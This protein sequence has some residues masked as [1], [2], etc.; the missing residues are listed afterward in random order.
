MLFLS[1]AIVFGA[2]GVISNSDSG[3]ESAYIESARQD[4]VYT[5][6]SMKSVK[7]VKS[8]DDQ[9]IKDGPIDDNNLDL[10]ES[11]SQSAYTGLMMLMQAVKLMPQV[12]KYASFALAF[13]FLI[14]WL[15]PLG[16]LVS[17]LTGTAKSREVSSRQQSTQSQKLAS[18]RKDRVRSSKG[19]KPQSRSNNKQHQNQK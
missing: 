13:V 16:S 7:D 18:S 4:V 19:G 17:K 8:R 5:G 15:N 9:P 11:A 1:L 2:I 3:S 10:P 6:G 12:Y 14:L